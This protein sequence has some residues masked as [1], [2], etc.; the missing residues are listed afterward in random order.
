MKRW[1]MMRWTRLSGLKPE[2]LPVCGFDGWVILV[3]GST[4][5]HAVYMWHAHRPWI[6]RYLGRFSFNWKRIVPATAREEVMKFLRKLNEKAVAKVKTAPYPDKAFAE[7]WPA[8]YE[9][10]TVTYLDDKP[11]LT[12]SL[13]IFRQGAEL[14]AVL[15][16][17]ESGFALWGAG[18]TFQ[19]VLASIEEQLKLPE[20]P[21]RENAA[22][23]PSRAR[24]K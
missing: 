11:R 5:P 22:T 24:K 9:Y 20:P 13:T 4:P 21:W 16:D 8:L 17:K 2:V 6:S 1:R 14:R 18:E 7:Q 19:D 23:N 10:M 3:C 12:S 15:N